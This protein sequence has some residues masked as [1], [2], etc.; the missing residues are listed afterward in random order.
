MSVYRQNSWICWRPR[1][2]WRKTPEQWWG[3]FPSILT[4][5][6]LCG[7]LTL[8]AKGCFSGS[9]RRRRNSVTSLILSPIATSRKNW[10][11]W[12]LRPEGNGAKIKDRVSPCPPKGL[13]NKNSG[14]TAQQ[15]IRNTVFAS[16][17]FC[18][19]HIC[20]LF[21][22]SGHAP[23]RDGII[24]TSNSTRDRNDSLMSAH[25]YIRKRRIRTSVVAHFE[26]GITRT[27]YIWIC[28]T[29]CTVKRH[30]SFVQ[31]GW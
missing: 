22:S 16:F 23:T 1:H 11:I 31:A 30:A 14:L 8:H 12:F 9:L 13:Q 3:T 21:P 4:N 6:M 15:N 27:P 26:L 2:L 20:F 18:F 25:T 7:I 19:L 28:L 24:H 17:Q 29:C 5:T 10:R